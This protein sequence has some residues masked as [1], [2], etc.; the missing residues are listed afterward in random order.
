[1]FEG[2]VPSPF[3]N[4]FAIEETA[5]QDTRL[6]HYDIQFP[7]IS[8]S[9]QL[10][11]STLHRHS[12]DPARSRRPAQQA[13]VSVPTPSQH[14]PIIH[15]TPQRKLTLENNRQGMSPARATRSFSSGATLCVKR[16]CRR[17]WRTTIGIY[18]A[19]LGVCGGR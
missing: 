12:W 10:S 2:T 6:R 15:L 4:P 17:T 14:Q 19:L 5:A 3:T 16:R 18:P 1:M 9:P 7:F 8:P 13:P 11:T